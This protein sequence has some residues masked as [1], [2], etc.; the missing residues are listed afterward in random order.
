M[1]LPIDVIRDDYEVDRHTEIWIGAAELHP[2]MVAAQG[3]RGRD[4]AYIPFGKWFTLLE[5]P[6]RIRPGTY[7]VRV[8]YFDGNVLERLLDNDCP[9]L[10]KRRSLPDAPLSAP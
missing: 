6:M 4:G 9:C 7:T 10:V 8:K 5:R 2:G 3:Y 1:S